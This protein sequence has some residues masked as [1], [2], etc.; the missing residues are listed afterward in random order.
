MIEVIAFLE[1]VAPF[2]VG[3]AAIYVVLFLVVFVTVL[4]FIIRTFR[5]VTRD[6]RDFDGRQTGRG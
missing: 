2:L 1:K 3:A 5:M 4:V 6:M